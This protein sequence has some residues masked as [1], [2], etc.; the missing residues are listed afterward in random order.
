[1]NKSK[2]EESVWQRIFIHLYK[3]ASQFLR[4]LLFDFHYFTINF[5]VD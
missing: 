3:K 1:M 4:S 5:N 2:I